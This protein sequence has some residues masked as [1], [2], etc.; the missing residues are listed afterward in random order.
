[1][2]PVGTRHS[3]GLNGRFEPRSFFLPSFLWAAA[4]ARGGN[5]NDPV[6]ARPGR[7]PP[8]AFLLFA[9]RDPAT[10]PRCP[11][12]HRARG[13]QQPTPR[14]PNGPRP[15]GSIS[16]FCWWR[17]RRLTLARCSPLAHCSLRWG[18]RRAGRPIMYRRLVDPCAGMRASGQTDRLAS[19]FSPFWPWG[20]AAMTRPAKGA[21]GRAKPGWRAPGRPQDRG[22]TIQGAHMSRAQ[23]ARPGGQAVLANVRAEGWAVAGGG[24]GAA[25]Q[26]TQ[27]WIGRGSGQARRAGG[28]WIDRLGSQARPGRRPAGATAPSNDDDGRGPGRSTR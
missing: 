18:K 6:T 28:R 11:F 12:L 10:R 26:S 25:G 9:P 5:R 20:G 15:P 1:M 7:L 2:P 19:P 8:V 14:A 13:L 22:R 23:E 3:N 24:P 4:L 17:R 16:I 21:L 27:P